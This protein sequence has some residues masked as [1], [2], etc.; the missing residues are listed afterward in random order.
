MWFSLLVDGSDD[1]CKRDAAMI[2]TFDH[3]ATSINAEG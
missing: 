1:N 3:N 2:D